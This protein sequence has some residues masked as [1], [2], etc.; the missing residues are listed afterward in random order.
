MGPV[1]LQ[2]I[3]RWAALTNIG[4]LCGRFRC[5]VHT[6][7][8]PAPTLLGFMQFVCGLRGYREPVEPFSDTPKIPPHIQPRVDFEVRDG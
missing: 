1:G 8:E 2:V 6:R 7:P 5:A 4:G 3:A